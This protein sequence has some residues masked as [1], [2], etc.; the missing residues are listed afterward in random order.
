[1][2][3]VWAE[4]DRAAPCTGSEDPDRRWAGDRGPTWSVEPRSAP[5]A[6]RSHAFRSV[7]RRQQTSGPIFLRVVAWL[8]HARRNL[9]ALIC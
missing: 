5:E 2:R 1:M 6:Q 9:A 7:G 8:Q 4:A 3:G